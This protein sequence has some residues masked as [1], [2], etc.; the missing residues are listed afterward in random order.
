M[1]GQLVVGIGWLPGRHLAGQLATT[2][3]PMVGLVVP[4]PFSRKAI[5]L[6]G[7]GCHLP[8]TRVGGGGNDILFYI[9]F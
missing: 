6:L 5:V 2:G 4:L 3:W 7:G 1:A 8:G 9:L